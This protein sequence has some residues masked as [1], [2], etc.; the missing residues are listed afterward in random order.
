MI[1]VVNMKK[2]TQIAAQSRGY[3]EALK[4]NCKNELERFNSLCARALPVIEAV[5]PKV[6]KNKYFARAMLR[7]LMEILSGGGIAYNA[8]SVDPFGWLITVDPSCNTLL[9]YGKKVNKPSGEIEYTLDF[10]EVTIEEMQRMTVYVPEYGSKTGE[11]CLATPEDVV[12]MDGMV[13]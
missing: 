2:S 1:G 12:D 10:K 3:I 7:D 5:P 9:V 13:Y 6:R 11:V 4:I 8:V